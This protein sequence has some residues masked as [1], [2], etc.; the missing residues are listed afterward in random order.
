MD[1]WQLEKELPVILG[2]DSRLEQV[3]INLL[4][5]ARDAIEERASKQ[6]ESTFEKKI[7]VKSKLKQDKVIIKISDTGTG[8]CD[9]IKSRLFDPFFTT[10]KIGEGTGLGL[11]I[12][13][14]IIRELSGEIKLADQQAEGATFLIILPVAERCDNETLKQ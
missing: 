10:K 6:G 7:T 2:D 1:V 4:M 12:S 14:G 5:N 13:Y 11:S 9:K 3:F 8:V